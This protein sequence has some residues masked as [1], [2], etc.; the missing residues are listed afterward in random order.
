M[1]WTREAEDSFSRLL[2]YSQEYLDEVHKFADEYREAVLAAGG[3]IGPQRP[4]EE[5]RA[6]Y[7]SYESDSDFDDKPLA[8]LSPPLTPKGSD[9]GSDIAAPPPPGRNTLIHGDGVDSLEA[10][11][12]SRTTISDTE[13]DG[14][15]EVPPLPTL[16]SSQS[17]SHRRRR[18]PVATTVSDR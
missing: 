9:G 14:Q 5:M 11:E 13:M 4:L 2:G 8:P 1:A 7:L 6:Q 15:H 12:E 18:R 16:T 10:A 3:Q 17:V